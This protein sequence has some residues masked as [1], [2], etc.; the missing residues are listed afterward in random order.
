VRAWTIQLAL[1]RKMP[2]PETLATLAELAASD[3][4][5]VV[6]LY[7]ASAADRLS[8]DQRGP[9][10]AG[11]VRRAQDAADHNLPL[12]IWYAAEP[13]AES[14]PTAALKL[15]ETSAI[16]LVDQFMTRRLAQLGT[17]EAMQLLVERL[18]RTTVANGQLAQLQ[19]INEGLQGRRQ[20]PMPRSWEQARAKLAK[21]DD[22]GV[23]NQAL[24]LGLTF[25]DA[26]AYQAVEKI[27]GDA[28]AD[29]QTRENALAAL[30]KARDPGLP[31][32]LVRLLDDPAL[33]RSAVRGLAAYDLPQTPEKILTLY[34]GLNADE[35]RDAL[36]TLASRAEYAA[37]LLNAVGDKRVP[38]ADLSA[39]L[40]RQIRNLKNEKLDARVAEVWGVVNDTPAERL[41]QIAAYKRMLAQLP[42]QPPD[43][44]LGRALFAKTCQQCHVLFGLGAKVGPE[45]TGSNRA[46]L[47]YILSN[48]LDPSAV[49]GKDY[50]AVVIQTTEGRTLTGLVRAED[51]TSLTLAT[52]TETVV[53]PQDEIDAREISAKSMMPDDQLKP[54]AEHEVRSLIAYLASPVQTPLAAT[55]ENAA[56]LF[57]GRDLSGWQGKP[58][59]WSVEDGQIVGRTKGLARNEFLCSELSA[60]DFRLTLE[61]KLVKNEGN[62]G[63][64][65][66]SQSLPEGEVKGYQADVGV[67]WWGKLYEEHGRGLLWDRSGE[68]HVKLG[69]WNAYEIVAVGGKL[70]TTI[71]G[72]PCVDLDDPDGAKQGIF[73][74]QLHSGGPTEVRFRNLKLELL[75]NR[76]AAAGN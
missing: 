49:I 38:A 32:I 43:V 18:G 55:A 29:R 71:N 46:N 37:E 19:Q 13:L 44:A 40:V 59:L 36:A 2:S 75:E 61:V 60:A 67:G 17:P 10:V 24:A 7:L 5:P 42:A 39:D 58:E 53:I 56:N 31:P 9:I 26:A 54:L 15:A 20:L 8:L 21:S 25:G 65:F 76:E 74:F 4:S 35:K 64:Q 70:R 16:P 50:Q 6:R 27:V 1:E 3:P 34:S 33:R 23:R 63:V 52:A 47:D 62:S 28:S 41:K 68:S 22:A 73:A 12:M 30:L 69:D 11:L 45:L 66:R 72:Q 14:S 51:Q 48:L 57:N